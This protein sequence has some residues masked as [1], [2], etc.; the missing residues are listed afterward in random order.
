MSHTATR[1]IL[2]TS[3]LPY[4]NGDIHLGHLLEY[5]Q[6]DI[7][8][9]FQKS[10][11]QQCY[12]VCADDAHGTAIMLRAEQEGITSETLIE[13]VSH[14]HQADFARFGVNFDNY[15]STHSTENR[16]F[17]ELIY[18][19]LRDKG[20]IATRDIEQMFD[21]QK[22]LF[23]ADRFIKG[24]CPKCHAEDQYGDNCEKCGATYTPAELI[25]PVSAISGATPEVRS[26]THYFFKLPDFAEF[27]Q[28]WINDGHVQPQIRNKLME[29]FESGFNEWDISRDAPYFGFEIPDAPGKYFYVW[30]DAPI[31]YLASFKNLCEREGIDFDSFWQPG[32]DAEVYHFIGKDIVYFHALFW[33]AML[34]GADFRTPTAVNCHGF[35]TVDGAKMSK[36]RGTFIKAATYADYLNPEYLRYYFAAK[37]TS[38][39]DDLDLNLDDFTA[40]VNS[41]LVG[42]VINIAS[43]CA[44]FVKKFGGS[45]LSSNC[46][47]P[48]MLARFIAA[49]DDIAADY[50][51]REFSR[52]M[53]HIMELADEANTYIAEAEPWVLA[54]QDGREQEVLDICSMGINLFRQLMVYLAPVVPAMAKEA[55]AFLNLDTLDWH[56]RHDVLSNHAINKFKPLMTRVER[57]KIDAMIEASKEDLVEEQKL[58]DAPKGPLTDNPIA[59]EISFD[60]FMRVDLRIARIAKAQYVEGADKLLQ[61]T[62]DIGGE[63]RNVFSG[64]RTSYAPEALEGRLTIMVANLAPRKMRFGVS[65]GM[66]LASANDE[67]IYLLS[68]DAGAEPGQRVT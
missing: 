16:Y 8:V 56:S 7:W 33:P 51:V 24:T 62:L 45:T 25:D 30:L 6:T 36:S 41:D 34:H 11:G 31:G 64:I 57:D 39:V 19:R 15:H 32:S 1:N 35:V 18:T 20:H 2:V 4:A 29:W 17:S 21:P 40:R 53:R 26:S 14:A 5:I 61:L 10:R 42:K 12:Y 28:K 44:G 48:Q 55:Q 50:E 13:R 47:D 27:L 23:L 60:D 66:V 38:K 59:D 67:G 63:T 43:R 68:P 22:G 3:A 37:L 58:K 46:A 65:E 49:G 52:A 54:K 9:R